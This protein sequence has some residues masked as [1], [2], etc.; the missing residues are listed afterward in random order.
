VSGE[1]SVVSG[2][3]EYWMRSGDWCLVIG[4]FK[5]SDNLLTINYSLL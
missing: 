3:C 5:L 4:F 2:S 1:K